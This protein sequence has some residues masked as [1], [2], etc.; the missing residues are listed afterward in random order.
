M[1]KVIYISLYQ[2]DGKLCQLM[3]REGICYSGINIDKKT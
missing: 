2:N 3:Y 1:E